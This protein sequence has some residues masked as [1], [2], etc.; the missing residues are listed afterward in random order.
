MKIL[1]LIKKNPQVSRKELCDNLKINPS[2]VQKHIEKLKA[3]GIIKRSG[4][5]KGGWWE[6]LE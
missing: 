5:A 2:A 3:Q 6:I 1:E 4:G